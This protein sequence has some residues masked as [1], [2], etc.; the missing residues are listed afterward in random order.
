ME[1]WRELL[2]RI[3]VGHGA[4]VVLVGGRQDRIIADRIIADRIIA[5]RI[6]ADRILDGQVWPGVAD[7]TGRLSVVELAALLERAEVSVGA[8]SA[9]A[10]LA[11]AVGTP[12]VV[13]LSGTNNPRQWQPCG[14]EVVVIRHEVGCSP[15]HRERCPRPGHPCMK[16]IRPRQ[17]A[18]EIDRLLRPRPYGHRDNSTAA[19]TADEPSSRRKGTRP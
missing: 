14:E 5:D 6:I 4:Q 15:C 16:L 13:L 8:D 3:I 10:H 9:P 19:A 11:A 1:H 7:W 2:G 17:V 12:V 18:A